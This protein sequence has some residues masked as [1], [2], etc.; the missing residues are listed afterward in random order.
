MHKVVSVRQEYLDQLHEILGLT[1]KLL[2]GDN[3]I[4]PLLN[5][6]IAALEPPPKHKV[7]WPKGGRSATK[8]NL[9]EIEERQK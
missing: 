8:P 3:S 5:E 1:K 9:Q 7:D 4:K 6:R 2:G